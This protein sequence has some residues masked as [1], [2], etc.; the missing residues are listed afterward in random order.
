M[1]TIL[2]LVFLN[3]PSK[4][5]PEALAIRVMTPYHLV[6]K[7]YNYWKASGENKEIY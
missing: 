6:V 5:R 4:K 3:L 2:Y 7:Y 1:K